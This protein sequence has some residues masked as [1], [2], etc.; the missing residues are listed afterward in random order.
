MKIFILP[1]VLCMG[2]LASADCSKDVFGKVVPRKFETIADL[3]PYA[4]EYG[5]DYLVVNLNTKE[6]K[7]S[8]K[9]FED[10][11]PPDT[12]LTSRNVLAL[13]K[14]ML[15]RDRSY[16]SLTKTGHTYNQAVALLSR[17][18]KNYSWKLSYSRTQTG[19]YKDGN[20]GI[21]YLKTQEG[22]VLIIDA[23]LTIP[24]SKKTTEPIDD[25]RI[26]TPGHDRYNGHTFR[27]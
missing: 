14:P 27:R 6:G 26:T 5:S 23:L 3:I 15:N 9:K 12:S 20:N 8:L 25:G 16:P 21:Y 19:G 10:K 18:I 1:L 11:Y 2:S 22:N 13:L 7:L 4:V 24:Y 17:G